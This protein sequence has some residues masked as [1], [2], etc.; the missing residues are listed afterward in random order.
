[1]PVRLAQST[2][3]LSSIFFDTQHPAGHPASPAPC[4][5]RDSSSLDHTCDDMPTECRCAPSISLKAPP[6]AFSHL[7]EPHRTYNTTLTAPVRPLCGVQGKSVDNGLE[8]AHDV[9]RKFST[10]CVP[11]G[12]PA[13]PAGG[14]SVPMA[15][16]GERGLDQRRRTGSGRAI[17]GTLGQL[18]GA[19]L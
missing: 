5:L 16:A 1:M 2:S 11:L 18:T 12:P 14:P 19:S 3:I 15:L 7:Y 17:Q 6:S 10:P 8:P 4:S 13:S 9:A